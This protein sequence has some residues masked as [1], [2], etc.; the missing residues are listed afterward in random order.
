MKKINL[1]NMIIDYILVI[2]LVILSLFKGGFYKSD[3]LLVSIIVSIVALIKIIFLICYN[4]KNKSYSIDVISVL[5]LLLSFSYLLPIIFNNYSDLN[6]SIYESIRYF[7]LYFVYTIVKNSDNKKIYIYT[8]IAI[9]LL[10]CVLS[11]DAVG[12]RYLENFLT[13]IDSGYLDRDYT[14]M[15]GTLQYA[16]V[17]AILCLISAIFT[18]HFV[19]KEKN[20]VI[21]SLLYVIMFIL[22]STIILTGCRAVILLCIIL[23]IIYFVVNR[24]N[25]VNNILMYLPL[26]VIIGIYTS[27]MY[28]NMLSTNVYIIFFIC[29]FLTIFYRIIFLKI[30][31]LYINKYK[32]ILKGKIKIRKEYKLTLCFFLLILIVV[33]CINAITYTRPLIITDTDKID[34]KC[35]ILNSVNENYNIITFNIR[36][37]SDVRYSIKLN[38]VD[39]ES[40]EKEIKTFNYYDNVSG[41]FKYEFNLDKNI[42][43]LKMYIKC[44]KGEITL[45]NLYLNDKKQKLDYLFIPNEIINRFNDLFTGST[46]TSDR[47]TYYIDALKITTKSIKNFVIGTGGEGFNNIYDQIKTKEYS[48]T[49]VH[50][51]FL[52]IFVETGAIGF[53]IVILLLVYGVINSKNNYIKIAYIIFVLHSFVDLNFSYMFVIYVFGILLASLEI[54]YKKGNKNLHN[55]KYIFCITYILGVI[56][57]IFTAIISFRAWFA[58]YMSIPKYEEES[59]NLALQANVVNKNEKRVMLDPYEFNYRKSMTKEYFT[60]LDLLCNESINDHEKKNMLGKEIENIIDNIC[61]NAKEIL[62]NNK[63][64]KSQIMYA[65]E[66][67]LGTIYYI[68]KFYTNDYDLNKKCDENLN[69]V[70]EKLNKVKEM[71]KNED[72]LIQNIENMLKR[73]KVVN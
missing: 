40:K 61:L 39:K 12:N 56:F 43:Y 18:N 26:A 47:I 42:K 30:Y 51:S 58:L 29:T 65:C 19:Q 73:Y 44:D 3:I 55:G 9:T 49:E 2:L 33:Y 70:Q 7:G 24:K 37:N 68:R 35:L 8:I 41:N 46:S 64:N 20:I 5:L 69:I 21:N 23:A 32:D 71:N 45:N 28:K 60:Y 50:S 63:Y 17:L 27:L 67:Y 10:Q 38:S 25:I 14:R 36:G 16:N 34:S 54:K 48:S 15:S 59:L 66:S 6:D 13:N 53:S 4:I 1:I 62:N 11:V 72:V 52:Q 57:A 22:L 31:N